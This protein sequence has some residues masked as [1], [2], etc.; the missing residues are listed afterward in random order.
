MALPSIALDDFTWDDLVAATRRHIPAASGGKWTLHAPVDPGVTL[1]E[2]YAWLIEQRAF[3]LDQV[4]DSLSRAILTLLG[5]AVEPVR[6]AATVVAFDSPA[7]W[8][9]VGVGT[10]RADRRGDPIWFTTDA[11]LTVLP[12]D[13]VGLIVSS[14]DRT[15]DLAAGRAVRVMPADGRA[16]GARVLLWMPSGPPGP[17]PDPLALFVEL[18]TAPSIANGWAPLAPANVPPPATVSFWYRTTAGQVV[19]WPAPID[20]GTGGLRRSG[21]VRLPVPVDWDFEPGSTIGGLSAYA[22]RVHTDAATFTAPP[23]VSRI[24]P[25]VMVARHRRTAHHVLSEDLLPLPGNTIALP[26]GDVP[27][28]AETVKLVLLETGGSRPWAPVPDLAFAGPG[29][30]VFVVDRDAGRLRFGDGLTGRLVR[31]Q[32]GLNVTVDYEVGGGSSGNLGG[33]MAWVD[34]TTARTLHNVVAAEGGQEP[35][36]VAAARE[37]AQTELRHITRA[38]TQADYETLAM[39]T[40]GVGL[41]RAHAAVGYHAMHPC[42]PVPGMV[43]VFVVPAAPREEPSDLFEDAFVATPEP[44]PGALSAARVRLES[45]RLVTHEVCV[46]SPIYRRATIRIEMRADPSDADALR[47]R[48]SDGLRD[49]LDPLI[50]GDDATGWP[51]GEPLRQSALL[52]VAQRIA[53]ADGDVSA[54]AI[55]LDGAPATE[56]CHDVEIGDH[57]LPGPVDIV[58]QISAPVSTRGGLR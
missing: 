36:T 23:R 9:G 40:P 55:G 17:R 15:S 45:A 53:G 43:T 33:G 14:G 13:H 5:D 52:R 1:L 41:A 24:V 47:R 57:T 31:L 25:N 21:V 7:P 20:D 28:I 50:G 49:F 51:F 3:W 19:P 22:I 26:D 48:L 12:V 10:V 8:V 6:L 32:P 30:R 38:I 16:A 4:P 11:G 44:D 29:D 39:T 35:E 46:R 37:R 2:L 34:E 54:V 18:R 27:P 42:T 58:V 56:N